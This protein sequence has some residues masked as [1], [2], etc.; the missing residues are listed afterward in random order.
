MHFLFT[1]AH[2]SSLTSAGEDVPFTLEVVHSQ[3][4]GSCVA[5]GPA[6]VQ[7]TEASIC[8]SLCQGVD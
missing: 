5:E 6:L 4:H 8:V 7:I 2:L 3:P 1:C